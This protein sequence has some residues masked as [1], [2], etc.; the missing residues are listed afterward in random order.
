[1][2]NCLKKRYSGY[3]LWAYLIEWIAYVV[4][5]AVCIP[6]LV[7]VPAARAYAGIAV[8]VGLIYTVRAWR[9]LP[10]ERERVKKAVAKAEKFTP[11]ERK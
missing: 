3:P 6:L 11:E 8:G 10:G 5:L 1:M 4:V 2:P 7:L 9:V